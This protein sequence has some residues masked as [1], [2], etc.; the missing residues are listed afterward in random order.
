M[1]HEIQIGFKNNFS[2]GQLHHN[3]MSDLK[4]VKK[5]SKVHTHSHDHDNNCHESSH[6]HS[7]I[8]T[9][10]ETGEAPTLEEH[11]EIL[12]NAGSLEFDIF[13][14]SQDI[15]RDKAFVLLPMHFMSALKL[16]DQL[17]LDE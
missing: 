12:K 6:K 13:K 14:F 17:D 9:M 5:A 3:H 4:M 7:S 2:G 8:Y 1:S 16:D 15:G 10:S 11:K